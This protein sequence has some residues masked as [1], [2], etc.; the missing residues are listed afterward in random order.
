MTTQVLC[1]PC[2]EKRHTSPP[3]ESHACQCGT[4]TCACYGFQVRAGIRRDRTDKRPLPNQEDSG[5]SRLRS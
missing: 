5:Q 4:R 3:N 1:F 2:R